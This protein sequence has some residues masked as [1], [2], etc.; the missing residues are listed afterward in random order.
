VRPARE[1]GARGRRVRPAR[2]AGASLPLGR[3]G[4]VLSRG[5]SVLLWP[6][7][8]YDSTFCQKFA[9]GHEIRM[10]TRSGLATRSRLATRAR[11]ATRPGLATRPRPD[12]GRVWCRPALV[13]M[14]WSLGPAKRGVVG[15]LGD[16]SA[17]GRGSPNWARLL[18]KPSRNRAQKPEV[19]P[20]GGKMVRSGPDLRQVARTPQLAFWDLS[21]YLGR[22]G[23][24]AQ[25][26]QVPSHHF[27]PSLEAA[28]C[29]LRS[30][31][32][33]AFRAGH[34]RSG[35]ALRLKANRHRAHYYWAVTRSASRG[36]PLSSVGR[37]Q[38]W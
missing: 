36:C 5:H 16:V 15:F 29:I 38:Q 32:L 8:S 2:E 18:S 35:G 34:S 30:G 14:M 37:A 12:V 3:S 33:C 4:G 9:F 13:G 6:K 10:A 31:Q 17:T 25:Q 23:V 21:R 11:L 28:G 24:A 1:A 20:E 7:V 26:F 27:A 22:P 19:H